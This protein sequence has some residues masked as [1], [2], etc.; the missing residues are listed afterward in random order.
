M[1]CS[2]GTPGLS[3]DAMNGAYHLNSVIHKHGRRL[4]ALKD[5]DCITLQEMADRVGVTRE[6]VRQILK[7]LDSSYDGVERHS[8]CSLKSRHEKAV[9]AFETEKRYRL[10]R[11][12]RAECEKRGIDFELKIA[13][14]GMFHY[15]LARVGGFPCAVR[16][17]AWSSKHFNRITRTENVDGYFR[18]LTVAGRKQRK[19]VDFVLNFAGKFGW[20]IVP[21]EES[22]SVAT[23]FVLG[24]E[25]A[26]T[27]FYGSVDVENLRKGCGFK[28]WKQYLNRWNPLKEHRQ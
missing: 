8:M 25:Y 10:L 7:R 19:A 4:L 6:R 3:K 22:F 17:Q 24:R 11:D 23:Y 13:S 28:D 1:Q 18:L 21:I 2:C 12:L 5:H 20:F 14:S 16:D 27:G 15:K 9:R 26:P